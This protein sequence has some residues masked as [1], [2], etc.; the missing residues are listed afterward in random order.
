MRL[1]APV[2]L[3][4]L[5]LGAALST[6]SPLGAA[7]DGIEVAARTSHDIESAP[8]D[9]RSFTRSCSKCSLK[10]AKT[11]NPVLRC[12]CPR[13]DGQRVW[14][15]LEL[16]QCLANRS[17]ILQWAHGY[18]P[19]ISSWACP[20]WLLTILVP[21]CLVGT[22]EEA[23]GTISSIAPSCVVLAP[24]VQPIVKPRP[25]PSVSPSLMNLQGHI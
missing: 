2:Q 11:N 4:L 14:A 9:K 15:E 25:S 6:A 20:A 24:G 3:L 17:G 18:A 13:T 19:H 12:E 16:N 7:A 22:L 8:V 21:L 10:N 1:A 23:A 5:T